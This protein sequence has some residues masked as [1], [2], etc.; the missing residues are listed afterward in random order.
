M[1]RYTLITLSVFFSLTASAATIVVN[2]TGDTAADD[3]VC[4]LREAI[5]AA[6]ANTASGA[7]GGECIAGDDSS[8]TIDLTGVSGTITL[9]SVLDTVVADV[10]I[11]GPG[12]DQLTVDAAGVGRVL[13]FNNGTYELSGVT[14]TGGDIS[15]GQ[16]AGVRASLSTITIDSCVIT[17]NQSTSGSDGAL[18]VNSS[19][20]VILNST[21]SNNDING[22]GGAIFV[23]ENASDGFTVTIKNS[24]LSGNDSD[25]N[26]GAIFNN[27]T[28]SITIINSTIVNNRA[29]LGDSGQLGGG[30]LNNS[31]GV[32]TIQNTIIAD[33]TEGTGENPDN[34]SGG[35]ITS[36]GNNI[37][38]GTDC[39][40]TATG[41]Q[42]NTD[43]LL[44]DLADYGGTT[45]TRSLLPGSSAIDAGN[46]TVCGSDS[47]IAG[48][49]QRGLTRSV[50][51]DGD[52]TATCDVG[53]FEAQAFT[54]DSTSD[55]VD[56]T[57]DGVCDDGGTNCTLRAA[58]QEANDNAGL[59]II[60]VPAG[61]YTLSIAGTGEDAAATGD[62][63]VLSH[64]ALA[65]AGATST[66]VDANNIDRVFHI[67][68]AFTNAFTVSM[69]GVGIVN[70]DIS[71]ANGGGIETAS[72]LRL[73]D[74]LFQL[75]TSSVSGGGLSVNGPDLE[76][77]RC[78]FDQN[79][80]TGSGG[81][82]VRLGNDVQFV[83]RDSL[84]TGNTAEFGGALVPQGAGGDGTIVNSTFS[85]NSVIEGG[86]A[87]TWGT[88]NFTLKNVTI[89]DNTAD[90]D[91]DDGSNH[92]GGGIRVSGGTVTVENSIIAGNHDD[93]VGGGPTV[94]P[95]CSGPLT[96]SGYNILGDSTGCLGGA[97]PGDQ[98][99]IIGSGANVI[100][101]ILEVALADNGGPTQT[102]A[103]ASGSPAIDAGNPG[104]CTDEDS[105]P[106]TT[107]QRGFTRPVNTV[108]DIG[109]YESGI[110]G[111]GFID[112]G[113]SCD[114]SGESP[115]CDDDCSAV[116]CGDGNHNA[117]AGEAC[118]G[119]GE[120][121]SCNDDCTL[122]SC[123]D[124]KTNAAAG[125]D[126]D[127]SGESATCDDDC[128]DA[129]C[130]DG[131]L[132][133]TA[134]ESCDTSGESSTCDDDCTTASCGDGNHNAAAGEGCDDGNTTDADG[135]QSD[136]ALPICGDGIVD[137]GED[138]DDGNDV[139]T[140]GC[141]TDCISNLA[142]DLTGV[143]PDVD[144]NNMIVGVVET[145]NAPD[146]TLGPSGSVLT[147]I[148][149]SSCTCDWTVDP[150]ARGSF[151]DTTACTTD[152][153]PE[154]TGGGNILVSVDC[155]AAGVGSYFQ[156]I[157][158]RAASGSSGGGCSLVRR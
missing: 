102:H 132:N 23:N 79:D 49:D 152:F 59:D 28:T 98:T 157:T 6:N 70:G 34:C 146:P 24:T 144:F 135:C 27:S 35:S 139:N 155:G 84:F 143:N 67:D 16:G 63:D 13:N 113:E 142:G 75:N 95:D 88:G 73:S 106:L 5:I 3:G 145:L 125:E 122:A 43:P 55:V 71:A 38:S 74:C 153:T 101:D 87:I 114:D 45:T 131:N 47:D 118:D 21:F 30:I 44:A 33:N 99:N 154:T 68:P 51:G 11:T 119:G 109:A 19:D 105:N 120:S 89:T 127:D 104:G 147:Q 17:G 83:I 50:D 115:T 94:H 37:E 126:C 29:D 108:C 76:I 90:S 93:S 65:G 111:D 137:T 129:T 1:F 141:T 110:C 60:F 10:V 32:V 78:H 140:D 158:V 18:L 39:G 134:G 86:G 156:K 26:G 116:S 22:D 61:T 54:V 151:A 107:D 48:V 56:D 77:D 103:L 82:A 52:T 138:C 85:G 8:E 121:A 123:G 81:G 100:A 57:I 40:F 14:I 25:N 72:T 15:S 66:T 41:D 62:L 64:L 112:P 69:S 2:D 36:S 117:M 150:S 128:T 96:S 12:A 130:G 97:G 31:T 148:A 58:I 133:T 80:A 46:Q 20:A 91:T 42:Q 4:T 7:M 53:A 149:P 9:G 124:G 92:D 136:C